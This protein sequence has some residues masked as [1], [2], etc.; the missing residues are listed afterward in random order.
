MPKDG[1]HTTLVTEQKA[2][3]MIDDA[4]DNKKQFFMMVTPVAPHVQIAKGNGTAPP[5]PPAWKGKFANAKAPRNADF[6]ADTPSGA[7]WILNLKKQN[8][9]QIDRGDSI[10]RARLQNIAGIDDMVE[11]LIN[12]L[13]DRK[14]LDNTYIIVSPTLLRIY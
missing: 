4:A 13:Q 7:S 10:H 11:S 5:P 2:L 3:H 9:G 8:Q 1:K 14:L 6:N 12:K